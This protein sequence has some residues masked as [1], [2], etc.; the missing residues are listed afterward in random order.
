MTTRNAIYT[1]KRVTDLLGL[2]RAVV[3]G[4]I[5]A[6]FVQPERGPRNEYMFSFQDLVLL[7]SARS[8]QEAGISPRRILASLKRL[9]S[10]L[11][12]KVPLTGLR[13]RAVGDQV[14][15]S[16]REAAWQADDGQLLMDFELFEFDRGLTVFNHPATP[17]PKGAESWFSSGEEL[18]AGDAAAAE[19]AYRE[20]LRI[21]PGH[22]H[23]H[24]NLGAML[25]E[26]SRCPEALALYDQALAQGLA[27]PLLH[28]NRAVALEDMGRLEAAIA[29]YRDAL[30]LD[31]TLA[32][33][34]YNL[35]R[36]LEKTADAQGALRHYSAYRRTRGA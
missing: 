34:H 21:D 19:R 29:A 25:C 9:R 30:A 17:E 20:A 33:A 14:V 27:H 28:F 31:P 24:L 35:A 7:R 4:L 23:S 11:P 8:L 32:D 3:A 36:L 15:A 2:S 5:E 13:I 18:E 12:E 16:E 26:S 1:A 10:T 6:G 22:V